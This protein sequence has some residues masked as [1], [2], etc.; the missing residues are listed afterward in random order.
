MIVCCST[1]TIWS[2]RPC[3][4]TDLWSID[5]WPGATR[6]DVISM[7]FAIGYMNN[8]LCF[9]LKGDEVYFVDFVSN[10]LC[11]CNLLCWA[12]R[13][14]VTVP[15]RIEVQRND[16]LLSLC[17]LR[18]VDALSLT[19][20]AAI[21]NGDRGTAVTQPLRPRWKS[22]VGLAAAR[23]ATNHAPY[24]PRPHLILILTLTL[25]EKQS[26]MLFLPSKQCLKRY[27][28]RQHLPKM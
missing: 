13:G 4:H 26:L 16:P 3:C 8:V 1:S 22:W 21:S 6:H 18:P 24:K 7:Q 5:F 11:W 27:I 12:W 20:V 2:R 14:S 17:A 10:F 23:D 25:F 28:K 15:S 19:R 9:I